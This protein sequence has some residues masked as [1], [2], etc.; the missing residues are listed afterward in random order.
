M[1]SGHLVNVAKRLAKIAA[2]EFDEMEESDF[3]VEIAAAL[4]KVITEDKALRD[5]FAENE[6][7]Y[8]D[9]NEGDLC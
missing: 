4:H 1:Y 6:R 7:I 2:A 5:L 9:A 3:R 8:L